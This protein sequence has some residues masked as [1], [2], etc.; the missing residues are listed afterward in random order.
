M[1]QGALDLVQDNNYLW[2]D[3]EQVGCHQNSDQHHV[4][5]PF[6]SSHSF[7]ELPRSTQDSQA[8]LGA[9]Q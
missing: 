3:L 6:G 8:Y 1:E 2:W 9:P 4:D 7:K 5:K